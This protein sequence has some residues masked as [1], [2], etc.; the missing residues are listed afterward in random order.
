MA[1]SGASDRS[2]GAVLCLGEP[3]VDLICERQVEGPSR[4]DSFAPHFGG[5]MATVA[6]V[7]ARAGARVSLAG[8]TGADEWGEWLR[9]RLERE[10]VALSSFALVEG[11]RT[12]MALV[13]LDDQGR[14]RYQLYGEAYGTVAEALGV[15]VDEAVHESRA[16]LISSNTLVGEQER[17]VTMRAREVALELGRPVLFAADLRA[18]RWRSRADAAASANACV[19]RA[20]LVSATAAEAAWMTGEEEPEAAATALLKAGARLVVLSLGSD[21]AILRGEMRARVSGVPAEVVSMLGV[22][23]ALTGTLVARLAASDFY[24]PSVAAGLAD[25][26]EQAARAS[27]RWGALD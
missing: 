12:L 9:D 17:A 21:G 13:L 5:G 8:G 14:P 23:S 18:H 4:A 20:M 15:R 2:R 27:E 26:V 25:A 10:G 16:L 11:L 7:A 3:L 24:P 22:G 19:P 1:A 6:A